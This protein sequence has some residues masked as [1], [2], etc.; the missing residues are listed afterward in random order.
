MLAPTRVILDSAMSWTCKFVANHN[1]NYTRTH[2]KQTMIP[3]CIKKH[4]CQQHM[5]IVNNH[6]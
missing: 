6:W 5:K 2:S 4:E 3:S 1:K